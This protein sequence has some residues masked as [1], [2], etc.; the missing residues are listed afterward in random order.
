VAW[1]VLLFGDLLDM[2]Q[3]L[4]DLSPFEHLAL[5]PLQDFRLT[6]FIGLTLLACALSAAGQLAFRRRDI[7]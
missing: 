4:Q 2:P 7:A 6:P 5:M 3:W 1:V